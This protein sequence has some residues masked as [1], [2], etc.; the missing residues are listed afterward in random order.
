MSNFNC[1][2]N[3][4]LRCN[5][6]LC[7]FFKKSDVLKWWCGDYLLYSELSPKVIKCQSSHNFLVKYEQAKWIFVA[8]KVS[9]DLA[10]CVWKNCGHCPIYQGRQCEGSWLADI[11]KA[12]LFVHIPGGFFFC[13]AFMWNN[14]I[15]RMKV[16][17]LYF[18]LFQAYWRFF[19]VFFFTV[20]ILWIL[21]H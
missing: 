9:F 5:L 8:G 13:C 18:S 15:S 21:V 10:V 1:S 19:N 16:D 2:W 4:S 6:K 7:L 3:F 11:S 12:V 14:Y 20:F 17:E